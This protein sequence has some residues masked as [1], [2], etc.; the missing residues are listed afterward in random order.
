MDMSEKYKNIDNYIYELY[1]D[2]YSQPED[3]GHS[4]L[5]LQIINHWMSHL[6]TVQNVLDVG[7][8][9]GFAQP[10]FEYWK[11]SYTGTCLGNDYMIAKEKGRNVVMV[12]FNFLTFDDESFDLVFSRHSLEHSPMPLLT[13]MEWHRVARKWLGLVLPNPNHFTYVG[14]NHYSV[15]D[16]HQIV[17]LLRRAGWK[18]IDYQA[19]EQEYRFLCEKHPRISYEGYVDAPL[20]PEIHVFERDNY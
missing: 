3:S 10:M 6:G 15:F 8:G 20:D 16:P 19:D 7:C 14:R 1:G 12:D 11:A 18:V 4:D 17:W 9:E 5:S 13:L 2:I